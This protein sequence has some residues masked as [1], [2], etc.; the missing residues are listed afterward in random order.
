MQ[1]AIA[2]TSSRWIYYLLIILS[3][4][5]YGNTI[6]NDYCLDDEFVIT[7]NPYVQK[8]TSGIYDII[9]KPY[10]KIGQIVLDYRP[11]VLISYAIELGILKATPQFSHL[12][13]I[14]LYAACLIV[15][16]KVLTKVFK[17][18]EIHEYLPLLITIFYAI[19][20]IHT[21]VVN[22]L[23]NRDELFS[24]LFG[25][26]FVRYAHKFN[27]ES[28]KKLKYVFYALLFLSLAL[29][30]KLTSMVF[31]GVFIL[32]AI[33]NRFFKSDKK[34]YL[35][36]LFS[37]LM[38]LVL[39]VKIFQNIARE[40]NIFEN[41]LIGNNDIF[42][43]LGTS[44][45]ILFYHL[46][47]LVFPF[48]FRFYYGH[49]MFPL[50]K[51][52]ISA[53]LSILIHT[54]ILIFGIIR[55]YKRDILGLFI[56][57]YFVAIILYTNFPVP[58]T[59]MF[60]ER[61][62]LQSSLWF[63]LI[64][65]IVSVRFIV[66]HQLF[67][68]VWFRYLSASFCIALFCVYSFMTID[69]NYFWK[70]NLTLMHHDIEYLENSVLANYMYANNLKLASKQAKDA[71]T[72]KELAEMARY[73][74]QHTIDL[75]PN[76][77]EFYFKLASTYRYNLNNLD[78]AEVN[79]GYAIS[80]DSLYADANYELSKLFFDKQDFRKSYY[81]FG[82]TY[83][84]QPTDSL[85]LF[86]YAQSAANIGDMATCFK[87]NQ[88][89]LKL[90]PNLQYPYLNL[91][92][93]YSKMLK[94]DSAVIYLDKAVALGAR[95]PQLLKQLSVYYRNKNNIPKSDY[96]NNLLK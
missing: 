45:K 30:S 88:E 8:G 34:N 57:C 96:Y 25:L 92:T 78:S 12:V 38:V 95:N 53:I 72:S 39:V 42:V 6:K 83:S 26:L 4:V 36:V 29:L 84:I 58:Y 91:G 51:I 90:Y 40:P 75:A 66:K 81:F 16:Y 76:Y 70:N 18:N 13:N 1:K 48:P 22:S 31:I 21:E 17:L 15:L 74:F 32:I 19:H 56:L 2:H 50:E 43:A 89:F 35:L 60:S 62:L 11:V 23:K 27:T 71:A 7:A 41:S 69:R 65:V 94:D 9:T 80:I 55:F 64:M 63:I 73:Y 28:E 87:I 37:L 93:Y 86:Y 79:F 46:K 20:P 10:A 68:C 5:L 49:N 82:K 44:F 3:F 61:A 14:L 52:D 47:M 67:D 59:G 33:F 24:L 77:P 54:I 85:T